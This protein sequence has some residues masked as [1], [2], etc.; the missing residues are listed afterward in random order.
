M[1][2]DHVRQALIRLWRKYYSFTGYF[3]NYT[4][5]EAIEES[6]KWIKEEACLTPDSENPLLLTHTGRSSTESTF[7][8]FPYKNN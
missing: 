8:C 7:N 3:W 6:K 1:A 4:L 2:D 5:E